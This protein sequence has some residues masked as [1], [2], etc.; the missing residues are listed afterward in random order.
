MINIII[1]I[2]NTII[3]DIKQMHAL[4]TR[5]KSN[6]LHFVKKIQFKKKKSFEFVELKKKFQFFLFYSAIKDGFE[7][8]EN[9]REV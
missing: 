4:Y 7:K 1:L 2:N 3:T 8:N 6:H 5:F 9:Y